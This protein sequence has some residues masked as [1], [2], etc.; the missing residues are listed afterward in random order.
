MQEGPGGRWAR[1]VHGHSASMGRRVVPTPR[2]IRDTVEALG[3][4]TPEPRR[5]WTETD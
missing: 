1:P 3:G 2:V 4:D 5:S